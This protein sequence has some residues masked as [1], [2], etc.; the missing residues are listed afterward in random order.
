VGAAGE[1][2]VLTLRVRGSELERSHPFGGARRLLA[3]GTALVGEHSFR[4]PGADDELTPSERR[5]AELA[6]AGASNREIA[7]SLF[8]SVRTVETHLTSAYRRLGISSRRER[9]PARRDRACGR[10]RPRIERGS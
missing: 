5:I 3:S 4:G 8:L 1:R 2:G 10:R 6:A 9:A 7:A